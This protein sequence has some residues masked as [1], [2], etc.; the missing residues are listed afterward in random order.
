[1]IAIDIDMK[2]V[3]FANVIINFVGM[4]IMSI[5]WW[6]NRHKYSGLSLWVLDWILLTGGSLLI[7]FQGIIPPWESMILSNN[8][9]IGGTLA[10]YFGLRLFAGKKSNPLLTY[11]IW[12]VFAVFV[13]VHSYYTYVH[14]DL[15]ARSYNAVIGLLLACLMGMWLMFKG[16]S[17][18]IRRISKSTGIAFAVIVLISV[19]R[20]VGFSLVP[21]TTNQFLQSNNYETLLVMLSMGAVAF[22]VVS[23][24]LMV[25]RRLY[26]E[27]EEMQDRLNRNVMELQAIFKTT[28]VGFGVLVN[29]VFKEANEACCQI[30]G[31]PREELIGK[32]TRLIFPTDKENQTIGQ[33]YPKI[34]ELGSVTAETRLIRKDGVVIN[35]ILNISAFD[36]DDL[37]KGIVF[38][39]LDI[40]ERKQLEEKANYLATFP[41]LNPNP[42]LELDREGKVKYQNQAMK[43]EFPDLVAAGLN[44]PFLSGWV[45][46]IQELQAANGSETVVRDIKVG[47]EYYE[48]AIS[49]L[50]KNQIRIYARKIT[51]RKQAE[52][53]LQRYKVLAEYSRD[54]ILFMDADSGCILEANIAA[55][56]AY[57]YSRN[58]LLSLRI[59]DL[60]RPEKR[61]LLEKQMVEANRNGILF[62][63]V[64]I[65]KDG[66]TFPVEVS[67]RGETIGGV[68]TLI[69]IVRDITER[70][71]AEEKIMASLVEKE[72]L[73]K[74]VHHRVK[75]N[76]QI[77]SSLLR[78]QEGKIKDK[79]SAAL[80][81]DSQNRIQ[82][83]SL[84]YNKLYQSE[85]L[86]SI[87]MTDYL[88]ELT[89]G[90]V[91]SYAVSPSMVT[92]HV[93]PG[94]VFLGV[95]MAI[96][97]GMVVNELVTNSLKYAFPDNRKGLI[98]ILLKE[99][100]KGLEL[101]VSDDGVGIP[102]DINTAG[103]STLGIKLV[104]NL[105]QDQLGGKMEL[106][107]GQG[108]TFKITFRRVKEEK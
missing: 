33:M 34:A 88:K 65:R 24:V 68:R 77:I 97:C 102:E 81:R 105:V 32:E 86:A 48:Q 94:N 61:D 22:L 21:Q 93:V 6:Q 13:A 10:L 25:N 19:I 75:N 85:N 67:A 99:D 17:T 74:E 27:A 53:I 2:T 55:E 108:T 62:E 49:P 78:L 30:L 45:Q 79:D 90:L 29:R 96:P 83:M 3:M 28:S 40:T 39:V 11:A 20:L 26:L 69:S 31:Y 16:V 71:Q 82:S 60:R 87:N 38:S 107:R 12:I 5:L 89:T 46:V 64:H 63:T 76:M 36:K 59:H 9:I 72:T 58:E 66:S 51:K 100:V 35:V 52:E 84:V 103:T 44:H 104:T 98:S 106:D 50:S 14:N 56:K 101:L 18:D 43:R 42:V 57:G 70:K 8:M 4:V 41:E 91:K 1:M 73:L 37:S 95:D 92:V 7:I 23:L 15:I 80:L 47:N 54:I